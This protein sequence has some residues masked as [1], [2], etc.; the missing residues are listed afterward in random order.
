[1]TL[2]ALILS[3]F[4]FATFFFFFLNTK[5]LQPRA[6]GGPAP[7]SPSHGI[8]GDVVLSPAARRSA[9]LA[10]LISAKYKPAA[11]SGLGTCL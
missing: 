9:P 5:K 11:G 3:L 4:S 8:L 6:R 1:M 7:T 10:S 2:E